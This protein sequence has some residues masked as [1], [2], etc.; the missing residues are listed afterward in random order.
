MPR[1]LHSRRLSLSTSLFLLHP[2]NKHPDLDNLVHYTI[3]AALYH[4]S[5]G[6][7]TQMIALEFFQDGLRVETQCTSHFYSKLECLNY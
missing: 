2:Y 6:S 3:E 1:V 7:S 5:Y 4:L